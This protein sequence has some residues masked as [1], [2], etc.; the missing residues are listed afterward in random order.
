MEI[1]EMVKRWSNINLGKS[2]R[3]LSWRGP[4]N[5]AIKGE[6]GLICRGP[7]EARMSKKKTLSVDNL[8]SLMSGEWPS[9]ERHLKSES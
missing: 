8:L 5:W 2:A 4:N 9:R 6:R 7:G 1:M 3:G